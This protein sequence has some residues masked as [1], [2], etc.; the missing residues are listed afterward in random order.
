MH[1]QWLIY[2]LPVVDFILDY[3]LVDLAQTIVPADLPIFGPH[4]LLLCFLSFRSIV[5]VLPHV[6]RCLPI[7]LKGAHNVTCCSYIV[8][9][10]FEHRI[11]PEADVGIEE[12]FLCSLQRGTALLRNLYLL[13]QP[14][15]V[16]LP[17]RLYWN[18]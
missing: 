5:I 16:R 18:S 2:W 17:D 7:Q 13:L 14:C 1:K 6:V 3:Q 10:R 15:Q 8:L 12:E 9:A 4:E 11:C